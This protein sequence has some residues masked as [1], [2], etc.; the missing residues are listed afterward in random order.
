M[1]FLGIDLTES[2]NKI[3]IPF[4]YRIF[5][6]VA[7]TANKIMLTPKADSFPKAVSFFA[8]RTNY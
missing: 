2:E 6:N 4:Y 7:T 8:P 3:N 5:D 1:P